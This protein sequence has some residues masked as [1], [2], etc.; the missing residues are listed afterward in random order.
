MS[1]G[2]NRREMYRIGDKV[3]ISLFQLNQVY[4]M[5]EGNRYSMTVDTEIIDIL[6]DG[7]VIYYIVDY[8]YFEGEK[9][10][11]TSEYIVDSE[12]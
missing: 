9:L 3:T 4:D 5:M 12:V 2:G 6:S 10:K 7:D 11:I 1:Y 8:E